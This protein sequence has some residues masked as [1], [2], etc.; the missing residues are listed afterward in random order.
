MVE[1]RATAVP[2]GL[3]EPVFD[4]LDARLAH[5]LMSVGAVKG[6]EIGSGMNAACSMG[7][8][9]NDPIGPDGFLS[10][11]AGGILGGISSGQD[12]VARAY[13]KPIPSI[14][15]EQATVT[16]GGEPTSITIGGRHDI[17]AIPRINPCS[18]QW[19]PWSSRTCCFWT[20]GWASGI[21]PV[22]LP[23]TFQET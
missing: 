21:R 11:N 9:N 22:V 5:A 13:V 3:G 2:A 19:R 17:A 23:A 14:S 7:S 8:L 18:R 20:V 10:N 1:V 12:I 15:Q 6:V 16:T 4:K